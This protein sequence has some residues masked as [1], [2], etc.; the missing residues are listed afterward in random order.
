MTKQSIISILK[1]ISDNYRTDTNNTV[2][3]V[4]INDTEKKCFFI[5]VTVGTIYC[6]TIYCDCI[7]ICGN[8]LIQFINDGKII[9]IFDYLAID[10]I[11]L[12]YL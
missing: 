10:E 9:A 6:G 3:M 4:N 2:T 12:L 5:R 11:D 8:D 7:K 1:D